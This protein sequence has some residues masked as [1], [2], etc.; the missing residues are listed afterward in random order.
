MNDNGIVSTNH[1]TNCT[2]NI[3]NNNRNSIISSSG[4][5]AI[6]SFTN[7]DLKKFIVNESK[8]LER[9]DYID[10]LTVLKTKL[11]TTKCMQTTQRGTY[12]D[13]D[14]LNRDILILL[15]SIVHSKIQRIKDT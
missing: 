7:T 3:S 14:L 8:D 15:Y 1:D 11:E 12:I 9:C 13:L 2:D 6:A 4:D 10:I 5:N